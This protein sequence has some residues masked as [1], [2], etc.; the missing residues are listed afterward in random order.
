MHCLPGRPINADMANKKQ[1]DIWLEMSG[2][3]FSADWLRFVLK[4]DKWNMRKII[5][6]YIQTEYSEFPA[7]WMFADNP[8][9]LSRI[10]LK[11]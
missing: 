2:L 9:E 10:Q 1:C 7:D 4:G 11:Q 8:T 3:L 5:Q 6:S